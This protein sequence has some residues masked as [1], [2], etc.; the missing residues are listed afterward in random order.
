[1][2]VS[3]VKCFKRGEVIFKQGDKGNKMYIILRGSV[4]IK[5]KKENVF[6]KM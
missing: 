2:Q 4:S 1:L 3:N 5:T 6:G